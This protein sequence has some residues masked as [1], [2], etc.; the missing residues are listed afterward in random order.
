[1]KIEIITTGG[2]I[3]GLE[4]DDEAKASSS[5]RVSI[6]SLVKKTSFNGQYSVQ[7]IFSKDSRFITD[8]D[9]NAI[10]EII[11]NSPNQ[12]ILITHG[13]LTMVETATSLG[14]QLRDKTI[15]L[16]GAFILGTK[17][18][19]DAVENLEFALSQFD[20]LPSGVYIAMHQSVFPWDNVNKNT[21]TNQFE[22]LN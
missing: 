4:Y 8:D 22:K 17:P 18:D 11:R 21:T 5:N 14:K 15:I 3:E 19:T 7:N 6:N 20:H 10:A 13:T 12:N 1:M 2:T 9:R 16:T